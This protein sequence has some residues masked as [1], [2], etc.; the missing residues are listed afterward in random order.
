METPKRM[1]DPAFNRGAAAQTSG[2]RLQTQ[3]RNRQAQARISSEGH[4]QTEEDGVDGAQAIENES[5]QTDEVA[6]SCHPSI[7]RRQ[8]KEGMLS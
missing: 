7:D 6:S 8:T 4:M 2:A 5:D 1:T 3:P